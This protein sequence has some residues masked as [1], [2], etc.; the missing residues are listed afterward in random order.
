MRAWMLISRMGRGLGNLEWYVFFC[1]AFTVIHSALESSTVDRD[2]TALPIVHDQ[3]GCT[4]HQ[5]FH[6]A[7]DIGFLSHHSYRHKSVSAAP[8]AYECKHKSHKIPAIFLHYYG[9]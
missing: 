7:C 3:K 4:H 8:P 6:V 5:H 1:C 2:A 9:N